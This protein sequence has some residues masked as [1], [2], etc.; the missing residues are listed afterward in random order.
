MNREQ[1]GQI[2][3]EVRSSLS[4]ANVAVATHY[5]GLTVTE[6][7]ELRRNMEKEGAGLRVVKNTMARLAIKGTDFEPMGDLLKGPT[8]IAFSKDPVAPAK[9]LTQFAKDHPNLVILGGVLDG[10]KVDLGRIEALAKLPSRDILLAQLFG[11][12]RGPAQ[13]IVNVLTAV[14]GGFVRVLEQIRQQKEKEQEAA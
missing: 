14:P 6:M 5:R 10:E 3:D 4:E 11:L 13:G 12:M 2:I 1:K 7:N 8:A 9:V